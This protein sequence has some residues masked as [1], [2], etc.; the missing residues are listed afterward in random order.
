LPIKTLQADRKIKTL[1]GLG[2]KTVPGRYSIISFSAFLCNKTG[3]DIGT[4]DNDTGTYEEKYRAK[5]KLI[6][7]AAL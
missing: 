2:A 7:L 5:G 6:P 4:S 3:A 1:E